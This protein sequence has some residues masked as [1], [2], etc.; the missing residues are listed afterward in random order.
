MFVSKTQLFLVHKDYLKNS[1]ITN[2]ILINYGNTNYRINPFIDKNIANLDYIAFDKYVGQNATQHEFIKVFYYTMFGIGRLLK[3]LLTNCS[4]VAFL[5]LSKYPFL[6]VEL[7]EG[8][9]INLI[10]MSFFA[11]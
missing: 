5:Q 7:L 3:K 6:S 4:T 8:P 11:S 9:L 10:G 1:K 2:Y